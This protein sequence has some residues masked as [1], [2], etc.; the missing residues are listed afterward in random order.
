MCNCFP[1]PTWIGSVC[2]ECPPSRTTIQSAAWWLEGSFFIDCSLFFY[3]LPRYLLTAL[4]PH[5][6][7][8]KSLWWYNRFF[9]CDPP[10]QFTLLS[11]MTCNWFLMPSQPFRSHKR[12]C[13][14]ASKKRKIISRL[15]PHHRGSFSSFKTVFY[16]ISFAWTFVDF[17]TAILFHLHQFALQDWRLFLDRPWSR[18][19]WQ[20]PREELSLPCQ[21]TP[22]VW[23]KLANFC[24]LTD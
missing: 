12:L 17:S 19:D 22:T 9:H 1:A 5:L 7:I 21:R 13:I 6:F 15:I 14:P 3:V 8:S 20:V 23:G 24:P 11:V 10:E 4:L 2:I 16:S 18:C